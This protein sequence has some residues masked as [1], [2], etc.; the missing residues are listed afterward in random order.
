MSANFRQPPN[1]G[2]EAVIVSK[3]IT[4]N[5]TY[6]ASSDNADGYD[7]VTVNVPSKTIVSKSITA[8]GTY[9]ASS[10]N[11]DGYNPVTVNVPSKNIVS[12]SITA[13]GTYNASAD[14]ADGFDPVVVN[15]PEPLGKLV[16]YA[17]RRYSGWYVTGSGIFE[18]D[19]SDPHAVTL[20]WPVQAGHTYMVVN[21]MTYGPTKN[22][23]G[24]APTDVVADP[25]R[26]NLTQPVSGWPSTG[27]KY[28]YV[29][30]E[31]LTDGYFIG[32]VALPSTDDGSVVYL[33]DVTGI[34]MDGRID[35]T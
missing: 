9:N 20:S 33:F 5:G 23:Y 24:I 16:P 30:P 21:G 10:D 19:T 2:A 31:V 32:Y 15:V 25:V 35:V 3:N 4:A 26:T 1:A 14:S 6:N 11:A 7:P 13:N 22:R 8:N 28:C 34:D 17:S 29:F 12:K 27:S 18:N